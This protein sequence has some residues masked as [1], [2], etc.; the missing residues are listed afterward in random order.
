MRVDIVELID[1][2]VPLKKKGKEYMACCPF[3]SEKTP[4][5]TVSSHKQFYHCF[6]CGA[7]GTAIG[8]LMEYDHLE[9]VEAIENLAQRLG[10][11]VP[12]EGDRRAAVAHS[13]DD[14]DLLDKASIFYRQSLRRANRAIDYLK[15][16][17]ITG[18]TAL[19]YG[20][21][22][23]PQGWDQLI[24]HLRAS[25]P[26]DRLERIGLVI[27]HDDGRYYDRFRERIM[28][29][30]RDRRG[31][32]VGFGGRLLGGGEPKYLNS[33]ETALFHKGRSLYGLFEA[34]KAE[35]KLDHVIVVEGYMDVVTL[36]Q[37]GIRNVV[38]TLGT[39]TTR[40]HI[41]QL[42]RHVNEIVFCFDGDRAGRDAAWRAAENL[43]SEFKD[44]RQARFMF[45]PEGEDPDSLIRNQGPQ[46]WSNNFNKALTFDAF[47]LSRLHRGR[48]LSGAAARAQLSEQA[49]PI[50]TAL[51]DGIFKERLAIELAKLTGVSMEKL[52][53]NR[54]SVNKTL[55][56]ESR[57]E[58]QIRNNPLR[59]AITILL[60]EP[61]LAL[62]VEHPE[63]LQLLD[64]PGISL[65][66]DIIEN[67]QSHPHLS[68]A[69]LLE[70]YRDSKNLQHLL[71]LMEWR[72]LDIEQGGLRRLF[73]DVMGVLERKRID[74]R[75]EWLLQKARL[76]G[77]SVDEKGELRQL[78]HDTM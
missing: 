36:A 16:R 18:Q 29:P 6:G 75:A 25:V 4:S 66:V 43:L 10:L 58:I 55:P 13:T 45:L 8:F 61:K 21:G 5:F 48:T 3:H 46:G 73:R 12:R 51:P 23:A 11:E 31:R 64:L 57:E 1:S 77:L 33:P 17:G 41:Q 53:A 35:G 49:K 54:D 40:E 30:I 78:I 56:E 7:H 27:R 47:L 71:K 34:R 14:Y 2:Y 52:L 74:Q 24:R 22:Y 20:L 39:A 76:E 26:I 15:G 69:S 65:L 63:R 72:P 28:F 9:F 19:E 70:R 32:V 62:E 60:N 42:Y 67:I 44:G 50:L 59:M 68:P 37:F 38:A